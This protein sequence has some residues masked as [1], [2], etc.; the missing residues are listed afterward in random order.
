MQRHFFEEADTACKERS[1]SVEM[2]SHENTEPF[3]TEESPFPLTDVD[4]Y[5]L[6]ITDAEYKPHTWEELKQIIG[7]ERRTRYRYMNT[8]LAQRR[9][10]LRHCGGGHQT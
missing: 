4:R 10:S 5:N 9:T 7:A 2:D 6:S 8:N 1:I 3:E